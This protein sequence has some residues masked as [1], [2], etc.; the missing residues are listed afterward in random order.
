MKCSFCGEQVP[1]GRGKLYVKNDG[2]VLVF[3]N[4]KCQ[5]NWKL[6]REGKNVKW[7]KIARKLK[8]KV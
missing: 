8:E 2:K 6:K 7:T 4:S 3:C 1:E 5:K